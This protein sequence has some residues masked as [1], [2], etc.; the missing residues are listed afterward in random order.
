MLGGFLHESRGG[1]GFLHR[2]Q[3]IAFERGQLGRVLAG[4]DH[5]LF[6]G[7]G[8]VG[9]IIESAFRLGHRRSRG[10][11][12]LGRRARAGAAGREQKQQAGGNPEERNEGERAGN[13]GS[14]GVQSRE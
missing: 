2:G 13:H 11:F 3:Q 1:A 9:V 12:A 8:L 5:G 14:P 4:G 6:D 7:R 10:N